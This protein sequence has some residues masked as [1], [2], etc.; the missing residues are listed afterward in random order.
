VLRIAYKIFMSLNVFVIRISRGRIGTL[1]A[2]QTIL[3]LHTVGRRS[4]RHTVTPI[5]YF[6]SN[7]FFFLIGSNW[8]KKQ[9]PDW[10]YNLKA[11]PEASIEIEGKLIPVFASQTNEA[12]YD[13]L[14][15]IAVHRYPPYQRYK[16]K[17]NRRIP[18]VE[19]RPRG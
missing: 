1:L 14:W 19:L 17:I 10:Y 12:E 8:G 2:H 11:Q 4:G 9:N 3:L 7:G 13:R 5:S 18:I 6:E 16:K 15:K